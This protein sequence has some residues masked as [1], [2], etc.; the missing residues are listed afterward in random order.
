MKRQSMINLKLFDL[1]YIKYII[2]DIYLLV[3]AKRIFNTMLSNH[4]HFH[5]TPQIN[6][7]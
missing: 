4:L 2:S 7:K 3:E 5:R 6:I 1:N